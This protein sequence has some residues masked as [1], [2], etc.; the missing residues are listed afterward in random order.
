MNI[1]LR[2][3]T[4]NDSASIAELCGQLGYKTSGE[5]MQQRLSGLVNNSDHCVFVA[6]VD[7]T[8]VGWIHAFYSLTVESDPLVEIAGLVIDKEQHRKGIGQLLVNKVTEWAHTKEV[9]KLRVRSQVIRKEAH[10]FYQ[11]IG[12]TEVKEQ[13]VFDLALR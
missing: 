7:Q 10:L 3:A 1:A 8:V 9:G 5:K 12:F 6:T 11:R 4:G 13:K 2:E